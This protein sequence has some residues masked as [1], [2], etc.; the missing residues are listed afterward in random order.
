MLK[1]AKTTSNG[2]MF[3][4]GKNGKTV[5]DDEHGIYYLQYTVNGQKTRQSLG[6]GNKKDAEIRRQ[7]Y[8]GDALHAN[9]KERVIHA[10]AEAR[11]LIK[12]TDSIPLEKAW[13]K[14]EASG[15]RPRSSEGTLGNYK[16]N[17]EAFTKWSK[18]KYPQ[19]VNI[20]Q[21]T[22]AIA[23][24][25][26]T[27]LWDKKI[28]ENTF[29][30]H[31]QSCNLIL[32]TLLKVKE[33]PF[34]NIKRE[35]MEAISRKDFTE[36]QIELIQKTIDESGMEKE[37]KREMKL[38]AHIGQYT[39]QRLVD[40]VFLKSAEIH[41]DKNVIIL[42]PDKTRKFLTKVTIPIHPDFRKILLEADLTQEYVLPKF[43]ERYM[44]NPDAI[45]NMF[46]NILLQAKI[47]SVVKRDRGIDRDEYGYHSY[48]H[49]FASK[50]AS[51]GVPVAVLAAM[52]GDTIRTA[53]KYY[54]NISD[55]AKM[56]AIKTLTTAKPKTEPKE[57]LDKLSKALK[58]LSKKKQAELLKLLQA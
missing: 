52:L 25:Y 58:S 5:S 6:T 10:I 9:T 46:L 4:R 14:Y 35:K 33:T 18:D 12:K 24:E 57:D 16:R 34:S 17:W 37:N 56:N 28:V 29:K 20:D 7:E 45:K 27:I 23:E 13:A 21:I 3:K 55:E 49:T 19:V 51:A 30:Y 11:Q 1:M 22:E 53:E 38:L 15:T 40:G 48:R 54:I 47:S 8:L 43:A 2:Y 39:G 26:G 42:M 31:M 50:M 44:H 41:L 32:K 36:S